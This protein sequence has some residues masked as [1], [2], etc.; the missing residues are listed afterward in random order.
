MTSTTPEPSDEALGATLNAIRHSAKSRHGAIRW[1]GLTRRRR[2]EHRLFVAQEIAARVERT[3]SARVREETTEQ[4]NASWEKA[5]ADQ[6]EAEKSE[7]EPLPAFNSVL[8]CR[9]CGHRP[10]DPAT[11]TMG[12]RWPV[13]GLP[14]AMSRECPAC[15]FSWLERPLDA[16]EPQ[17]G[18]QGDETSPG[19]AT[20]AEGVNEVHSTPKEAGTDPSPVERADEGDP[21]SP[22]SP[23]SH[24]EAPGR[25]NTRD[26]GP[27]PGSVALVPA[28]TAPGGFGDGNP[29]ATAPEQ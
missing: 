26:D 9:K 7:P 18:P 6:A 23:Q 16:P 15:G 21:D 1:N 25:E 5:L 14:E 10:V 12:Y 17:N 3:V 11:R 4:I 8:T 22:E 28:V 13:H 27:E 19:D 20:D 24:A 29:D 2:E